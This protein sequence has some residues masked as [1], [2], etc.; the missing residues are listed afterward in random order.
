MRISFIRHGK[1]N[2][3]SPDQRDLDR[4]LSEVGQGQAYALRGKLNGAKFDF[5][6]SSPADRAVD[7][8]VIVASV[9]KESIVI[10]PELYP[11]P[12]DGGVGTAIDNLFTMPHLG[13]CPV[14]NYL[15]EEGGDVVTDWA[16]SVWV[17]ILE[18]EI[19]DNHAEV[20]IFG[21]AVCLPALGMAACGENQK[22]VEQIATIN[23]G[24][25]EG[26]VISF[27]EDKWPESVDLI[28]G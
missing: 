21:H 22:L 12:H 3:P 17:S 24:E 16:C 2:K 11:N 7:T 19:A 10:V 26:F 28:H 13:Y 14:V 5:V 27:G 1:A 4:V 18:N 25:C 23:L 8:G 20:A 15:N 9:T 6:L